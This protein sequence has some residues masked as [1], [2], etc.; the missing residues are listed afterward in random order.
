MA[1]NLLKTYPIIGGASSVSGDMSAS[2]TSSVIEVKEQDNI[3]F[4]ASWTGTPVGGVS[5]QVSMD[6][7][8]DLNGNVTNPGTWTTITIGPLVTA[9]GT[10]DNAYIE[11]NQISTPYVRMVYTRISGTGTMTAN[12]TGKGI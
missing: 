9:A 4:Q 5:L 2:I 10:P 8:R 3:G 1:Y 11:L 6:F 7:A 12:V